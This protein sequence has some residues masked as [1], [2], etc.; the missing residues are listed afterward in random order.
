MAMRLVSDFF[1]AIKN[2]SDKATAILT[3][4]QGGGTGSV[5][6]SLSAEIYVLSTDTKPTPASSYRGLLIEIDV[7]PMKT[8]YWS[9]SAW[10][11][12]A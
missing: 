12:R 4:M 8:Y 10:V 3:Q 5:P 2:A 9:G 11:V 1:N 6:V 7:V